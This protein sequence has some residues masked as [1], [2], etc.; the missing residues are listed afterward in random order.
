MEPPAPGLAGLIEIPA[1]STGSR[2]K[3]GATAYMAFYERDPAEPGIE[4]AITIPTSVEGDPNTF[5]LMIIKP[6]ETSNARNQN[7]RLVNA[8]IGKRDGSQATSFNW[9]S[10]SVSTSPN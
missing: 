7:M 2:I 3:T 8:Q 9:R 5:V 10:R 1:Y 4:N 6:K